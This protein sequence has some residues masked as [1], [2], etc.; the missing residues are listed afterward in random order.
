MGIRS[1]NSNPVQPGEQLRVLRR[2]DL[3]NV[4][5]TSMT[6]ALDH[7]VTTS[8]DYATSTGP[9]SVTYNGLLCYPSVNG[10]DSLAKGD[11]GSAVVDAQGMLLGIHMGASLDPANLVGYAITSDAFSTWAPNMNLA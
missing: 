2:S 11:S 8:F 6:P 9:V 7:Y 5:H 4:F 10:A 3:G 1:L